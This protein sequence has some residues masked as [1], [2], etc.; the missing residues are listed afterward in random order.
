MKDGAARGGMDEADQV[1]PVVAVLDRSSRTRSVEAP[2]FLE[3]RFQP[4]AVLV[5]RPEFDARLRVRG[6]DRLDDWSQL[7]LNAACSAGSAST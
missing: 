4:D 7:F 2:H 5:D 3:D 1:A 6:R